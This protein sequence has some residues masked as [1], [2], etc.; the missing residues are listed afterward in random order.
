[1]MWQRNFSRSCIGKWCLAIS[2]VFQLL[3]INTVAGDVVLE[4]GQATG[5][6]GETVEV[7]VYLSQEFNH[8]GPSAMIL[9]FMFDSEK[10]IPDENYYEF[11][12]RMP[13]GQ[14]VRDSSGNVSVSRSM[15]RL[16][17]NVTEKD[18]VAELVIFPEFGVVRVVIMGINDNIITT[19]KIFD[20]AFKIGSGINA[21]E[22][23]MIMW[24]IHRSSAAE[25]SGAGLGL[26][27]ED[28]YITTGCEGPKA[29]VGLQASKGSRN[30]VELKWQPVG[31]SGITYRVY[32]S[33]EANP[34]TSLPLG[35][36]WI[37]GTAFMDYSAEAANVLQRAGCR[38][39]VQLEQIEY[40]YWV[41]ARSAEGCL[42]MFSDVVT[43][44][45]GQAKS[46]GADLEVQQAV[47]F[48]ITGDFIILC[49][50]LLVLTGAY[51]YVK[52]R[53]ET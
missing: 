12:A 21:G 5:N 16:D 47:G 35:T 44:Y 19:G 6:P 7:P 27:F 3:L 13:T 48:I 24:E 22:N 40:Y 36:S 29:P 52:T 45:R 15:L 49:L 9:E 26:A 8:I 53:I 39:P 30:G 11:I 34:E 32:R 17:A 43:G 14:I 38:Q 51:T 41:R 23:L 10:L 1:M 25:P 28:G 46:E 2:F 33:L 31:G 4:I 20:M 18:K 37:D 50:I 42:G